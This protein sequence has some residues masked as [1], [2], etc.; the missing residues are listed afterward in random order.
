MVSSWQALYNK[1]GK[2]K[3]WFFL[4]QVSP[5]Q[6]LLIVA[7]CHKEPAELPSLL[8]FFFSR[9]QSSAQQNDASSVIV[10]DA[11]L[12]IQEAGPS[13]PGM[14]SLLRD[15][16]N[17]EG[18]VQVPARRQQAGGRENATWSGLSASSPA[19]NAAE[20]ERGRYILA[21][22]CDFSSQCARHWM[23]EFTC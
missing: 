11:A 2:M 19:F 13:V 17:T 23:I 16:M 5:M 10:L 3:V 21:Q 15:C 1:T 4:L 20:K 9:Y 12:P 18:T 8:T 6:P 22:V 7:T 14:N